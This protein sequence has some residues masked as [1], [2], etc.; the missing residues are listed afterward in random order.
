MVIEHAKNRL[1]IVKIISNGFWG[2]NVDYY[3]AKLE[4]SG[5]LN[6]KFFIPTI[7][8]SIGEQDVPFEYICNII[9]YV[10]I[11]YSQQDLN[12]GIV[13]TKVLNEKVSKLVS[14]YKK[15]L[16]KYGSFPKNRVYITVSYYVNAGNH[17]D[18]DL[19]VQSDPIYNLLPDCENR[20][21]QEIGR[22][23]SPKIFMKCDGSCYSCE[24]FNIHDGM[25]LGNYFQDGLNSLLENYNSN[26]YI[27]FIRDYGVEGFKDVIPDRILKE[28][29]KET[30]CQSCQYCI[31][32]C[33]KHNL[34]R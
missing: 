7:Q 24:V 18:K 33:E 1:D 19:D 22:F 31:E 15:Y 9:N 29:I 34:L 28:T 21:N 14:L 17:F 13:Y 2:I 16:E 8:V 12:I 26:K 5:L 30:T 4:D 3:F 10:T 32:L 25:C 27:K 11:H 23:V 6:N 20:F